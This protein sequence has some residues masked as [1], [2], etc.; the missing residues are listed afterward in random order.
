MSL[1]TI[2]K[3]SASYRF[4]DRYSDKY[5]PNNFCAYY[6][7]LF[8]MALAWFGI[9][10]AVA[11]GPMLWLFLLTGVISWNDA[12]VNTAPMAN[13]YSGAVTLVYILGNCVNIVLLVVLFLFILMGISW[14]WDKGVKTTKFFVSG[15]NQPS[16]PSFI[17]TWYRAKKN[18]FC[19]I[20]EFTE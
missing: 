15:N 7:K 14:L 5:P 8:W 16:Q 11:C 18:K 1:W 10:F 20:I 17:A 9:A 12:Y 3:S 13:F 19:P 2:S 6:R 4:I